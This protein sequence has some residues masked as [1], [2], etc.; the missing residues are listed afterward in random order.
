[1]DVEHAEG[2]VLKGMKKLLNEYGPTIICEFHSFG[3]IREAWKILTE[4]NYDVVVI[5]KDLT[6][7]EVSKL[8]DIPEGSYGLCR[9][10]GV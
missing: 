2:L 8:D 5:G 6:K 9:K 1:M 10:R 4:C 3:A 7:K